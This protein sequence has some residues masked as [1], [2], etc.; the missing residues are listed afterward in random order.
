MG[1][2]GLE[3]VS[4]KAVAKTCRIYSFTRIPFLF[5]FI[6]TIWNIFRFG[7]GGRCGWETKLLNALLETEASATKLHPSA[8]NASIGDKTVYDDDDDDDADDDAD[9]DDDGVKASYDIGRSEVALSDVR[10]WNTGCK[11]QSNTS[12]PTRQ[13]HMDTETD[14]EQCYGATRVQHWNAC[15]CHNLPWNLYPLPVGLASTISAFIALSGS[16]RS[17]SMNWFETLAAELRSSWRTSGVSRQPAWLV[18]EWFVAWTWAT[19]APK[20]S[21]TWQKSRIQKKNDLQPS[22]ANPPQLKQLRRLTREH[23]SPRTSTTCMNSICM[24]TCPQK[25][26]QRGSNPY[27]SKSYPYESDPRSHWQ[28][29]HHHSASK[30]LRQRGRRQRYLLRLM[31]FRLGSVLGQTGPRVTTEKINVTH[32]CEPSHVA[33]LRA[34]KWSFLCDCANYFS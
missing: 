26:S 25:K 9:D 8:S 19:E 5:F 29:H 28:L 24:L 22:S 23:L 34:T 3:S 30:L 18:I 15:L 11:C 33:H 16:E 27:M 4:S 17:P 21:T 13:W 10:L 6:P 1:S 7:H 14:S 20:Q 12:C 2:P 32:C 31:L